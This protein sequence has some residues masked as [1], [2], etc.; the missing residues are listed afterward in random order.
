MNAH[1]AITVANNVSHSGFAFAI[2]Q[3]T[4]EWVA[5]DLLQHGAARRGYL[6]VSLKALPLPV[7]EPGTEHVEPGRRL[8]V[9]RVTPGGP[10]DAAGLMVED[11]ILSANAMPTFG[12]YG[13]HRYVR[14]G[15]PVTLQ[16]LR[17]GRLREM[18][19]KPKVQRE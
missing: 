8:Q 10:A 15:G 18:S 12:L 11:W 14:P 9:V 1:S 6:G 5:A 13:L 16:V 19:I 7:D 2:P 4:A 17:D 3:A